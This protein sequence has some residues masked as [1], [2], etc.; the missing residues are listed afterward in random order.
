MASEWDVSSISAVMALVFAVFALL[1]AVAQALQQY[2]ITG[3]LIRLCDS[4]VFGP[5]PGQGRRIWQLSQFRF[6]VVY[7]I[8]QISLQA[9]LWPEESPYIKSYAIGGDHLPNLDL[10][11]MTES[12]T[13][14]TSPISC[15]SVGDVTI[16]RRH[17]S[18]ADLES[19]LTNLGR[20]PGSQSTHSRRFWPSYWF[21]KI[22]STIP[23]PKKER[24]AI[25]PVDGSVGEA[26]W[27]SFCKAINRPCGAS[28]RYH[29]VTYDADRCPS[30]L[31]TA[32]MQVSM[33][34]VAVMGLMAGMK[35]ASCSFKEKSI[36]MH[37][38]VGSITSSNHAIL[39]PILHFTPRTFASVIPQSLAPENIY[40][41]G[42]VE[43]RWMSRT[44]GV[45]TVAG[46]FFNSLRRRTT[47]RL[48]D[49]W[50]SYQ[51]SN[52]EG[53]DKWPN[54]EPL[55]KW[56]Q[57]REII[58]F[59]DIRK[60]NRKDTAAKPSEAPQQKHK[61]Q[62]I[63]RTRATMSVTR[64]PQDGR[65]IITLPLSPAPMVVEREPI[66]KE[67]EPAVN[68][69][70]GA[71]EDEEVHVTP[72]HPPESTIDPAFPGG[73]PIASAEMIQRQ[74]SGQ[75]SGPK[76][77]PKSNTVDLGKTPEHA[78][79]LGPDQANDPT[80]AGAK[81]SRQSGDAKPAPVSMPT[82]QGEP[83]TGASPSP[84]GAI[85]E[86]QVQ[87]E[88]WGVSLEAGETWTPAAPQASLGGSLAAV[89][90]P[91]TG[92]LTQ[93]PHWE[94]SPAA[95]PTGSTSQRPTRHQPQRQA[96]VEDVSDRGEGERASRAGTSLGPEM[97]D[98]GLAAK[99]RQ[100]AR[101][102]R[103]RKIQRDKVVIEGSKANHGRLPLEWCPLDQ[104]ESGPAR[105]VPETE[106]EMAHAREADRQ[107]RR[108]ERERERD[109]RNRSRGKVVFL[110]RMDMYWFCQVDIYRGFWATSWM[111]ITPVETSLA[112]AVTVILEALLGF[113]EEKASLIYCKPSH[114]DSTRDWISRGATSYPA[115]A[116]NARGGVIAQGSYKSVRVK[117]FQCPIPA[118]E[119]LYSY[120]WQVSRS[121]HDQERYCEAQ[122][123]ELMRI[124]A[125]LSYVGRTDEI[126]RGPKDL[127]KG[128][129]ALVQLLQAEFEIDF[130]NIDL[131]AEEGGHQDIQ[132]LAD[133]VMDF[134]TDEELNEAEQLYMLVA[135]L[136]AVK[137]CQSILAGSSTAEI[138]EILFKDVQA[139]LV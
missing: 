115:Y 108:E 118:L 128:A 19:H 138:T 137:V 135:L 130:M 113:L 98:R 96:T 68:T 107:L 112:G 35:V 55:K 77:P 72:S 103:S 14:S 24:P 5:L 99:M 134:L 57:Q 28:V 42:I 82:S 12:L 124:D 26:S 22:R 33:R 18:T 25:R 126:S 74:D 13:S 10:V 29:S 81:G 67:S 92:L 23:L 61:T 79:K 102:E 65:W 127:L 86:E 54:Y 117:A 90:R 21:H 83:K 4:V 40:R 50:T 45:C 121:L 30:D 16:R 89:E 46:E 63:P 106:E 120:D 85:D 31:V 69:Q 84:V 70:K 101:N 36:S 97:P 8:P 43:P 73:Q 9:D 88:P 116:N 110:D 51:E 44:W 34:D 132:G 60:S 56:N 119:L 11:H 41:R 95:N 122:N 111:Y 87:N 91:V 123:V 20:E 15:I 53:L 62:L 48:D 47:R 100:E 6:R 66:V 136:R 58:P 38:A 131:S 105:T 59:E 71:E 7:S 94:E 129:P 76:R 114:F 37:G 125:W 1:V 133:S 93:A 17:S 139:H 64:Q 27:V 3:Q 104:S 32:P 49:R 52:Q 80:Q 2:L 109:K 75:K 39:G 78:P